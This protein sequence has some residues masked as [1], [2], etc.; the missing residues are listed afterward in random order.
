MSDVYYVL[1]PPTGLVVSLAEAKKH[2]RIDDYQ[3]GVH[4]S[5]TLGTGDS[6]LVL[7]AVL[8]GISGNNLQVEVVEDGN[9]TPLS[10]SYESNL[11]TINLATD[12]MGDATSTVNDVIAELLT[13]TDIT[14]RVTLSNGAGS[15]T[16]LL[17]AV[18]VTSLAGG[19]DGVSYEDDYVT[20]LCIAGQNRAE[21]VLRKKL[22]TTT[23]VKK[24]EG[25]PCGRRCIQ[26]DYGKVQT[27]ESL[28]YYDQYGDIE[29]LEDPYT[30]FTI[31][32]NT[33]PSTLELEPGEVWPYVENDRSYP[34][35][36]TYTV[37]YG[38][39]DDVPE[40]IKLAIKQMI[41]H[42]Y[43]N[44]E[45]VQVNPGITALVIPQAAEFLL[46]PHRDFRF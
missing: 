38:D 41:G 26:L 3:A 21:S 39:S 33:V 6:R 43:T 30:L 9:D 10:V 28:S 15:G 16:G 18:S 27:V 44:R 17:A 7:T 4:A 31:E 34:L 46:W 36:I 23:M 14:Q 37:G 24:M 40:E 5:V 8:E 11:I 19:V 42:W 13:N 25:F 45:S 20:A 12:S 29:E 32:P 1:T 2:L 35:T 22:L